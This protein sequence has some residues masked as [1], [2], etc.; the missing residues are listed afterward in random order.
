MTKEL[1]GKK[2][3]VPTDGPC[4]PQV[5]VFPNVFPPPI[6]IPPDVNGF[7][8][9]VVPSND[10][11]DVTIT[12]PQ[13]RALGGIFGRCEIEGLF[14]ECFIEI[15]V[16]VL[17]DVKIDKVTLRFGATEADLIAGNPI[18]PSIE[19]LPQDLDISI[20][21]IGSGV[22]CWGGVL[23]EILSFGVFG[24]VVDAYVEG[25]L[26]DFIDDIDPQDY[27]GM[28]PVPPIPLDF[29]NIDPIDL[30]ALDVTLE[31]RRTEVEITPSGM[32]VGLETEF[33]P[34]QIDPEVQIMPGLPDS[35]AP[36]PQPP[37]GT[38][39]LGAT[40]LVSDDAVNQMLNALTRNGLIKTEY[41][42]VQL[43]S[44]LLP[45]NC[46]TLPPPEQ[47]QCVAI[48]GQD[49]GSL[50][51]DALVTCLATEVL[52]DQLNLQSSTPIILHGRLD[53]SP[54]FYLFRNPSPSTLV[55][56]YRMSG[57]QVGV[58]ADRDGDG[59]VNVAYGAIPS[60]FGD[61]PGTETSCLLW[62]GC[63]D[64]NVAL[65]LTLSA[66]PGQTPQ[67]S[68]NVLN[69]ELSDA[70]GCGGGTG[71]PAGLDG[72]EDV[73]ADQVFQILNAQVATVPPLELEGLE[74][75]NIVNLLNLR[76]LDHGN[77][78]SATFEDYFGITADPN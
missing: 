14:G 70:V 50:A 35:Q 39:A 49:C 68:F 7:V 67:I 73:F 34:K 11:I 37:L 60:C 22:G 54:K 40:L 51:G 8:V 77:T 28:I 4:D 61:N 33:I 53:A 21:D 46:A 10:R 38:P 69:V 2:F 24:V 63:F 23:A 47:G 18:V 1:Q 45:G 13:T 12:V 52:L 43:L 78:Y 57:V 29:L 41:E 42:D 26:N 19:I 15:T 36:L 25:E 76:V 32:A 75:G 20:A 64:V 65:E 72:L 16:F 9:D 71:F 48:K 74:F 55:A 6:F 66:P 17:L 27:L 31:L 5:T 44:G 59:S 56:Y 62:T 30:A 3:T 58:I